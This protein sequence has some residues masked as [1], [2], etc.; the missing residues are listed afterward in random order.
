MGKDK[1]LI[2]NNRIKRNTMYLTEDHFQYET[3]EHE[4]S[5]IGVLLISGDPNLKATMHLDIITEIFEEFDRNQ[6]TVMRM[7]LCKYPTFGEYLHKYITQISVAIEEFK[8][9]NNYSFNKIWVVGYSFGALLALNITLR[10]LDV[11]GFVMISPLLRSYDFVN[12]LNAY[13]TGGLVVCGKNDQFINEEELN[14]YTDKILYNKKILTHKVYI[15]NCDHF[16]EN[17]V[18][19]LAKT[20]AKFVL[21]YID[22]FNEESIAKVKSEKI[23]SL[24]DL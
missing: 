13:E 24:E 1:K 17:K 9:I 15:N 10:R 21:T 3:Y 20:V 7:N 8:H 19:I 12:W 2:I 5:K 16:Y 22:G 18:P 23:K 6:I 11:T 14:F 4:K